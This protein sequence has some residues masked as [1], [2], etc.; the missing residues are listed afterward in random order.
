[1]ELA[2]R[3]DFYADF[4]YDLEQADRSAVRASIVPTVQE[5]KQVINEWKKMTTLGKPKIPKVKVAGVD[6]RAIRWNPA[7]M[8]AIC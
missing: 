4:A 1:M 8:L 5:C 3:N 6:E 7:L 2:E